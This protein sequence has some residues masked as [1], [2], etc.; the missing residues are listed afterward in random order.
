METLNEQPDER[1]AM[2]E[3]LVLLV[4]VGEASAVTLGHGRGSAEDKR[5]IYN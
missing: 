3:P 2:D 4:S 5:K 1:Q